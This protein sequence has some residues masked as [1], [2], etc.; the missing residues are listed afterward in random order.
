M[1]N[2]LILIVLLLEVRHTHAQLFAGIIPDGA[3]DFNAN[4]HLVC[5]TPEETN[6]ADLD[7]NGDMIPDLQFSLYKSYTA[8]DGTNEASVTSLND[9]ITLCHANGLIVYYDYNEL[10][11]CIGD[12]TWASQN[13]YHLGAYGGW[14]PVGPMQMTDSHVYYQDASTLEAG[15]INLSFNLN[16]EGGFDTPITLDIENVLQATQ[17]ITPAW[18]YLPPNSVDNGVTVGNISVLGNTITVE[19]LMTWQSSDP[20]PDAY[21]IVSKHA[22]MFDCNY[23]FRP[24]SF[25][26]RTS[27]GFISL[28]NP[29]LLCKDSTYHVAGTYDG[30]SIRYFV[31]GQQVASAAWTGALFENSY[32]TGI[33]NLT[34]SF[35]YNEQFAGYIDEVRIWN[36][37]R[38]QEELTSSMYTLNDPQSQNGLLACYNFDNNYNNQQGNTDFNGMSY[39]SEIQQIENPLYAGQVSTAPCILPSV[40]DLTKQ[41]SLTIHP[42]PATEAINLQ[43]DTP[44]IKEVTVTISDIL[45]LNHFNKTIQISTLGNIEI[46]ISALSAGSHILQAQFAS[47]FVSKR[48]VKR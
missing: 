6:T 36:I 29:K 1:K 4:I 25:A 45:G 38:T 20:I 30:D 15:W 12:N 16:D 42:N 43:F 11:N 19:A 44:T 41:L 33:G 17:V 14:T 37:A 35:D 26:I 10:L 21:D 22:S 48:F 18:L 9:N 23:L 3:Q 24:T 27:E 28:D 32:I 46:D 2:I 40:E 39:G 7:V 13:T 8:V 5:T 34:F 47:G 31:N